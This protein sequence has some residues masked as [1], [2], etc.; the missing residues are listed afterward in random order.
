MGEAAGCVAEVVERAVVVQEPGR[1]GGLVGQWH[2][3]REPLVD[4]ILREAIAA[5]EPGAL[6]GRGAGDDKEAVEATVGAA[7]DEQRS[8]V[9]D[10][11]GAGGE[12]T[13]NGLLAGQC[14]AW[15]E[16]GIEL[17]TCLSVCEDE[18]AE[19]GAVEGAG[20]EQK[21]G[22]E[23]LDHLSEAIASGRDDGAGQLVGIDDG[24]SAFGENALDGALPAGDASRESDDSRRRVDLR[25]REAQLTPI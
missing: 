11:W 18:G 16:D 19:R 13:G 21:V 2:L 15:M 1:G 5:G 22:A 20:I 4:L 14:D 25:G 10:E 8:G 12:G 17:S 9:D 3:G 6:Q 24:C 7:L 23:G